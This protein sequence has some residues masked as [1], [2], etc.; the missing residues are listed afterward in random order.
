MVSAHYYSDKPKADGSYLIKGYLA[1]SGVHKCEFTTSLA[2][3]LR[4]FIKLA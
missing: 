2:M 4:E 1:L 3:G